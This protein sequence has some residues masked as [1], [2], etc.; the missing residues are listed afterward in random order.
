MCRWSKRVSEF[1]NL[2]D[3]LTWSIWSHRVLL[4]SAF[5][6]LIHCSSI[7]NRWAWTQLWRW[8]QLSHYDEVSSLSFFFFFLFFF[9]FFMP[10]TPQ[11][12]P[13]SGYLTGAESWEFTIC[14]QQRTNKELQNFLSNSHHLPHSGKPQT[15][16]LVK[17]QRQGYFGPAVDHQYMVISGGSRIGAWRV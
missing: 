15:L 3:L 6:Y 13:I 4:I 1:F 7:D 2:R 10:Q 11:S 17:A 5:S 12:S 8:V 9:F 16:V 14:K